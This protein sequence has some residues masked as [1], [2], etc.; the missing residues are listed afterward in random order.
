MGRTFHKN[1]KRFG[2]YATQRLKSL[3]EDQLDNLR[4]TAAMEAADRIVIASAEAAK[5]VFKENASNPKMEEFITTLLSL[6][7]LIGIGEITLTA[8][9]ADL[10]A[11]CKL[12]YDF[13]TLTWTNLKQ[14]RKSDAD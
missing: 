8:V 6:L 11:T 13:E 4:N 7:E 3:S 10:E 9:A 12:K 2:H 14:S 1:K 5:K